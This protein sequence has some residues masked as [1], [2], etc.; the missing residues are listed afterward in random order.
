MIPQI[1]KEIK[2]Y[3]VKM[4]HFEISGQLLPNS[5]K[6]FVRSPQEINTRFSIIK[7]QNY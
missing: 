1:L 4:F 3:D 6:N 7:P 2:E 5:E